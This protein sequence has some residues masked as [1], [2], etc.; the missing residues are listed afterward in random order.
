MWDFTKNEQYSFRTFYIPERMM[1]G[2]ERYIEGHIKPGGF[3]SAVLKN[4]LRGAI[5][6]ADDENIQNLPAYIG[7]LYNEAPSPC[8]GSE[9]KFNNWLSNK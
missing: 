4:D 8:W 5:E 7:F 2:L 3:L 9:K 1:H 6:H